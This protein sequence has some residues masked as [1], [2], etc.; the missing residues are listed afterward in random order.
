M[1]REPG[2]LAVY[3]DPAVA[4]R[5]VRA[6]RQLGQTDVRA[7]MPA[8]F[9]ELLQSIDLPGSP[10]GAIT[11]GGAVFGA[12]S[13]LALTIGTS[14]RMPLM[15]GGKPIVSLPAFLVIVFELTVMFGAL[16]NFI[17]MLVGAA[18]GRRQSWMPDDAR[19]TRDR[20]GVFL[21]RAGPALEAM[22]RQSGAEEIRNVP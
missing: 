10:I 6:A 2:V 19:F 8:P 11:L 7:A 13:G 1:R 21:P 16:A 14:L 17:A 20:I 15:V 3:S 18:L 5:A 12:L 4:A 9:P 22:L